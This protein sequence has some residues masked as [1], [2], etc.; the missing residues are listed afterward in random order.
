METTDSEPGRG[1]CFFR[2]SKR[3]LVR[4]LALVGLLLIVY[5]SCFHISRM[6]TESMEPTL[7]GRSWKDSDRVLTEKVSYLIRQSRRW[8]I[9]T[10]RRGDGMQVMKRVIGLPGER[11]K[12][13]Q[14][15]RLFI[16]DRELLI[17]TD[18]DSLQY[19]PFGNLADGQEVDCGD[20]YY[21][22]G[23][24]SRDSDD[25]RFNGPVSSE[26]LIGRAWYIYYP[27][28]RRRFVNR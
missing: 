4:C 21:V 17:P 22:M 15:G 16:N 2:W 13:L 6:T 11:I 18:L 1:R 7:L 26:D 23:D 19:F 10:Y 27:K 14:D 24:Y 3:Q 9:I 8:E 5:H 12:M 25:S 28:E 20:G